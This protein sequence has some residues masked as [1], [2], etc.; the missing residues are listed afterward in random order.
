MAGNSFAMASQQV[1]ELISGLKSRHAEV[2]RRSLRE[3]YRFAKT[4][5]RE[6]PQETLMQVLDEFNQHI[7]ALVSSYDTND[8]KAGVL[9][10]GK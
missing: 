6:M 2:R 8:R 1:S 4:E 10:I 7:H 5:L 9:T 3:L